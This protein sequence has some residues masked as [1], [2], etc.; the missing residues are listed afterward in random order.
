MAAKNVKDFVWLGLIVAL[1]LVSSE[2]SAV[3]DLA[4]NT[5]VETAEKNGAK[6]HEY[7]VS[8]AG[9]KCGKKKCC[10]FLSDG[11]TSYCTECCK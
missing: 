10:L 6:D 9:I 4:D 1:L 11:K 3:K 7:E 2:V 8:L 5:K